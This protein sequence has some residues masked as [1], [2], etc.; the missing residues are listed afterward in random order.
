M[1]AA[2]LRHRFIYPDLFLPIFALENQ[3]AGMDMA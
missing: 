3:T 1:R 2:L